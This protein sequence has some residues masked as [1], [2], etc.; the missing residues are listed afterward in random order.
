MIGFTEDEVSLFTTHLFTLDKQ[1]LF[2]KSS[3]RFKYWLEDIGVC[4]ENAEDFQVFTRQ[5]VDQGSMSERFRVVYFS[6]TYIWILI[7]RIS[8]KTVNYH[9]SPVD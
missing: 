4:K 5:Y 7:Q 8:Y 6:L 2:L 3:Y 1:N 9:K